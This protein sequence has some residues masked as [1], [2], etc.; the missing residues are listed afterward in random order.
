MTEQKYRDIHSGLI[1]KCRNGDRR[2]QFEIYKLYFKAM[3]NTCLRIVKNRND[4]E[5]IVQE[6][7]ISA[8]TNLESFTGKVSFGAWLKKIV[9]NR[10]IDYLK[11]NRLNFIPID[12]ISLSNNEDVETD[13][14][15]YD[16][17]EIKDAVGQL[18]EGYRLVT[19]LYLFEGYDHDEIGE[20]L[21]ISSSASRSQ[22]TR[23]KKKVIEILENLK[24]YGKPAKI[25]QRE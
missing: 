6:G 2:S 10:S 12:D 8:Y 15:V 21:G 25:H 24:D 13:Y 22:L 17:K 18:A 7:F 14:F 20:I 3:Y 23:A 5:D 11:K 19:T 9:I 4:A 1:E 16:I